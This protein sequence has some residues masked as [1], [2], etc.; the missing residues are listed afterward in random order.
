METRKRRRLSANGWRAGTP[1]DFLGLSPIEAALVEVRVALGHLV[2]AVRS[3][4]RLTQGQLAERLES[5]QSRVAKLEA[6]DPQVS[7]DLLVRA[8]LA[9]GASRGELGTAFRRPNTQP[10]ARSRRQRQRV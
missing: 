2:R 1:A 6:G 7:L 5:S 9:A 10:S 3:R 8:A 4:G